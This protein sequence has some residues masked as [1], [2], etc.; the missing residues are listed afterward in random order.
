M[1]QTVD[2]RDVFLVARGG[3]AWNVRA[4]VGEGKNISLGMASVNDGRFDMDPSVPEH[5]KETVAKKVLRFQGYRQDGVVV[6]E[7]DRIMGLTLDGVMKGDM[8]DNDQAA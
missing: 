1:N 2:E 6:D 3:G 7:P 5:L 4:W 8:S